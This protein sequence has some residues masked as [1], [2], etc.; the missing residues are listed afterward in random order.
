MRLDVPALRRMF[1]PAMLIALGISAFAIS[2]TPVF[3]STFQERNL[4]VDQAQAFLQGRLDLDEDYLDV[5][6]YEGR[7]YSVFPPAPAILLIP[8]VAVGFGPKEA[9]GLCLVLAGVAGYGL[10]RIFTRLEID[11]RTIIWLLAAFFGGTAYWLVLIRGTGVWFFSHVVA[12][13]ALVLALNEAL[14]KGRGVLV[15]LL[16]GVA[17]LSRQLTI[18]MGLFL[19]AAV[20]LNPANTG[21][22]L[23]IRLAN[24]AGAGVMFALVFSVYLALN[25]ARFGS[26]LETGYR[27]IVNTGVGAL[28]FEQ[29]GTFSLAYMPFNFIYLFVQGFHTVFDGPDMLHLAGMDPYGTSLITASP[30]VLW[31][32]FAR[33]E[34]PLLVAAW[35]SIILCTV[36]MLG[37]Y[38]N[39]F[40]QAN[41]HRFTL[42]F[43]PLLVVLIGLGVKHVQEV[44]WKGSIVYAV[45]LN[46]LALAVIPLVMNRGA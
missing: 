9:I 25:W 44:I 38:N 46:T 23:R 39:G 32:L 6:I 28:R 43:L 7:F 4:H 34:K 2:I 3:R 12:V 8:F 17:V 22:P 40:V 16:L 45:A 35:A 41:A 37:Y 29:Y 14:G 20:W 15:G 5:A 27:Y 31:A 30:F 1:L 19:L 42:D 13:T 24:A 33:W 26:P 10:Y 18:Y 11:R 36:H 21:K